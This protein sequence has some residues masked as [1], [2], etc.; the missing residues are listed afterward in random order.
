MVDEEHRSGELESLTLQ[1][2]ADDCYNWKM[3]SLTKNVGKICNCSHCSTIYSLELLSCSYQFEN[4]S[5]D[6][7]LVTEGDGGVNSVQKAFH[8]SVSCL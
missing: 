3:K 2:D 6:L 7:H 8:F 5:L 1:S 4:A